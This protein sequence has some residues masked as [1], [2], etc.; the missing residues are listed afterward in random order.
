MTPPEIAARGAALVRAAL[1]H[2]EPS[3]P[4]EAMHGQPHHQEA[5]VSGESEE[6]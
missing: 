1:H 4:R 3:A 6:A 2:H 5:A